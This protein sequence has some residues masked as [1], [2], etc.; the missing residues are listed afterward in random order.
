MQYV[1][2]QLK[3]FHFHDKLERLAHREVTPP[4]HIRLKPINACNHR[5]FYCCYRNENLF[6]SELMKEKDLIPREKMI[7]I[8]NDLIAGGVKAVTFT[9]GGEPLIY[10][11]IDET[12]ERLCEGGIRVAVLTNGSRL[13]GRTAALLAQGADW[14]RISIDATDSET[15]AKTRS[16]PADEFDSIIQQMKKFARIKRDACELGINFIITEH[17]A[18]HVFD[19]IKL[20]RDLGANHVKIS[21]CIISTKGSENNAYHQEHFKGVLD[22]ILR[23]ENELSLPTFHV[24]NK[25]HDFE[26]K[27]DKK[28]KQCPFINF[29]NVIA[30]DQNIYTCQ[31]K[32]YTRTGLLGS[33]Q[34]GSLKE[35]WESDGYRNKILGIDPSAICNHHCVQ[36]G[37]N[38]MLLDYLDAGRRH[39][40]FV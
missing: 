29:I 30:A 19:F 5:C 34:H 14:V 28:Y 22:Q 35:L 24:I 18:T 23:A 39:L 17:N 40:E 27:F 32:A 37:K 1:Y 33:V 10:P 38:L 31:D 11:Y 3:M 6:L 4:V 26:D 20:M 12:V 2:S 13:N 15:L 36:H 25:F 7:E 8:V 21:E 9:G 16:V